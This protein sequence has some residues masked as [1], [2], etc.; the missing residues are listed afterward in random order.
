MNIQYLVYG[1]GNQ[2]RVM[3][4]FPPSGDLCRL[5]GKTG[6]GT[7][8]ADK[9]IELWGLV[10]ATR[11][12]CGGGGRENWIRDVGS[13]FQPVVDRFKKSA[14]KAGFVWLGSF[15][16]GSDNSVVN[17]STPDTKD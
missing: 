17:I 4:R 12:W 7:Y 15:T 1:K 13:N 2:Y 9:C 6:E 3:K 8:D 5:Y 11:T 14:E 16:I 10:Q